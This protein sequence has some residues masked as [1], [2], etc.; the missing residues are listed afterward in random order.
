MQ[1]LLAHDLGT[2]GNKAVLYDTRGKLIKSCTAPYRTHYFNSSWAEQNPDDWWKAVCTSTNQLLQDID[3]RQIA[4]VSFSGHMMGCLCMDRNGLPL[5]PHILYCDARSTPQVEEVKEKID[6]WTFYTITGH[7]ASPSYTLE[8]LM[9]IRDNE[10]D[11]YRQTHKVLN[12]KDY[13]VYKLTGIFGTDYSDA[14]GTEAF[15]I[16]KK[17]WSSLI[18][19]QV[20][21]DLEKFP[22]ANESTAIAGEVTESA[23]LETGIPAGTPVCYGAGDG[24]AAGVGAGSIVPGSTY[25]CVGSS[26]W[27]GTTTQ[28]PF[29][30]PKQRTPTFP[31][32]VPGLYHSCGAMQTAGASFEWAAREVFGSVYEHGSKASVFSRMEPEIAQAGPGANGVLFLPYLMGERSPWWDND[33]RGCYLGITEETRRGDLL[34]AVQEGVAFNL[35]AIL[36]VYREHLRITEMTFVGGAAKSSIWQ[37]ILAD[38]FQIPILRP[39]NIEECSS[40]GAALIGGVGVGLYHS[41]DELQGLFE[42]LGRQIPISEHVKLYNQ[43]FDAFVSAYQALR[44]VFPKISHAENTNSY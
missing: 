39:R 28:E 24:C 35:R 18:A 34:R 6:S 36:D 1:Y 41:F 38:V 23:S 15:D 16:T 31:H 27:V 3:A 25:T 7:R 8:K 37:A 4:A 10:P 29:F 26:A 21:I 30:D 11:T 33:A 22:D 5:R 19:D 44:H 42:I 2:S 9:W 12:A 32:A 17:A 20:A 13:I 40:M 14:G 43:R